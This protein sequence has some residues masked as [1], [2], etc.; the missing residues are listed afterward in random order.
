MAEQDGA[1]LLVLPA[2]ALLLLAAHFV[3]GG[4]WPAAALCVALLALLAVRRAWSARVLQVALAVGVLEW[5][6]TAVALAQLRMAHGRPYLRLL[7]IL[8]AVTAVT[9]LAALVFQRPALRRR[10]ARGRRADDPPAA[11]D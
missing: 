11:F 5:L 2:L 8:G 3:H 4:L 6:W 7:L 9:A 1:P 10:F